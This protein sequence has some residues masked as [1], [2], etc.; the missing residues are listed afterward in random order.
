MIKKRIEIYKLLAIFIG[1][2]IV[3][4]VIILNTLSLIVNQLYFL[5]ATCIDVKFYHPVYDRFKLHR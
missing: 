5:Y 1:I 2:V 3:E 4:Y